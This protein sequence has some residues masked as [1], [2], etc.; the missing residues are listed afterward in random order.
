MKIARLIMTYSCGRN[1][2]YCCNKYKSMQRITKLITK[3]KEIKD[4]DIVCIT[5]GEPLLFPYEVK[6]L[7]KKLRQQNPSVVIYLYTT[8]FRKHM[9]EIIPLVNGIHYTLHENV[10]KRDLEQFKLFQQTIKSYL[11]KSFRLY[12]YP[13]NSVQI[14]IIPNRWKR[15]EIKQWISET[16][17]YLPKDETLF[18]LNDFKEVLK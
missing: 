3:V 16:E 10:S 7:I 13:T 5:G 4:Y 17:L 8:I 2:G 6:K 15:I 14:P 18:Y 1:C 12:V 11:N 9:E